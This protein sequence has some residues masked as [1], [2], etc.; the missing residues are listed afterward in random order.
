MSI[1]NGEWSVMNANDLII[2][3]K[4]LIAYVFHL[5]FNI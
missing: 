2:Q 3:H 4:L 1:V 5:T